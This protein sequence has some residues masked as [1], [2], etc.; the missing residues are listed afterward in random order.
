MSVDVFGDLQE[1][2]CVL[3]T[4][5]DLKANGVLDDH[6]CGLAR[7]VRY[8]DNW[9]VQQEALLAAMHVCQPAEP[10][11]HAALKV[12]KDE[13]A[14]LENRILAAR[15]LGRLLGCARSNGSSGLDP[16]ASAMMM[17]ALL[18]NGGPPILQRAIEGACR[19]AGS[20]P[21]SVD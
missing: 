16:E 15:V 4:L 13:E 19:E 17:R 14:L 11:V 12:L 18:A 21:V 10:L 9:R 8:Q 7:L 6:Q 3:N 2:G 1:W 5:E 20:A